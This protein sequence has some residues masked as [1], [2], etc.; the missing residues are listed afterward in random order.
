MGIRMRMGSAV[1][2]QDEYK[3]TFR[4]TDRRD[5]EFVLRLL[6]V[7]KAINCTPIDRPR[8]METPQ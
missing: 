5:S 3:Y 2:H 1:Y 6:K 8:E 4:S 7:N